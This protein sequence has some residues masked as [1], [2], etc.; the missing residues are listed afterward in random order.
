VDLPLY[1][2]RQTYTVTFALTPYIHC[3]YPRT[4]GQ[5]ELTRVAGN[6]PRRWQRRRN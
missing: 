1:L 6:T 2:R 5:A 4:D 3:A